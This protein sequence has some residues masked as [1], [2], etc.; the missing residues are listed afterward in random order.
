MIT[1]TPLLGTNNLLSFKK[2]SNN[3]KHRDIVVGI[4]TGY[5]LDDQGLGVQ[6]PVGV[7]IF[8]SP[9]RP[10]WLWGPQPPI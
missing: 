5:G 7:R 8:S 4:A 1:H 10:D 9:R 2:T 6:V 3:L